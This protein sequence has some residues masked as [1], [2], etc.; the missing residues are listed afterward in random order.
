MSYFRPYIDE[1]G[2]HYPTYN[3]ILESLVDDMQTIF[4]SGIYLGSDSQDYEALSKFAEKIYD[5]YQTCEIVY[6]SHSPASSFGAAL[7]YIV[8]INGITRKQGTKSTCIVTIEGVP[9][10][11]IYEGAV[12]DTNGYVWDLPATVV[13]GDSGAVEVEAVCREV[14]IVQVSAD[15]ITRILTPTLGWISVT[16]S[17]EAKT[18]TVTETDSEL[19]ARQADSVAQ[20]SQSMVKGLKGAVSSIADVERCEVYENDTKVTNADGIPGNSVCV[21]VEGGEDEE[22]AHTILMR[23]GVGC[24]TYGSTVVTV[25]EDDGQEYAIRF[26]RPAYIDVDVQI[27]ISAKSGYTTSIPDEIVGAIVEYLNSFSIGAD[28]TTSIL[29]MIAQQV[30]MDILN[31]AF[32]IISVRAARHGEELSQADIDFAFN[33][34]ARGNAANIS[35][36]LV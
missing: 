17:A 23:K 3:D 4:G 27:R 8:A 26:S 36:T 28:L 29:W 18:G 30:N 31:P 11:T 35:V 9:G 24:G 32:S 5:S 13:I 2:F 14:G 19:R 15:C 10:T 25:Q 33:E 22:I 20:P 21:V 34:V 1:S 6:H 16:N 7:D 12:A